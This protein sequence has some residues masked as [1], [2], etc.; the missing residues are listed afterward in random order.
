MSFI[1]NKCTRMEVKECMKASLRHPLLVQFN[2]L[3]RENISTSAETYEVD[4]FTSPVTH[5]GSEFW[6]DIFTIITNWVI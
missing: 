3:S 5:N 4:S 1:T 2:Y 6:T